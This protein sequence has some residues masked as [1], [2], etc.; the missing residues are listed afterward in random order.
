[1][2]SEWVSNALLLANLRSSWELGAGQLI[3]PLTFSFG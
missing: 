2:I 3:W 1:M